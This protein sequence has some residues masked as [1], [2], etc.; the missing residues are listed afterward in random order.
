MF[1]KTHIFF[2]SRLGDG[3]KSKTVSNTKNC[4][5]REQQQRQPS[6]WDPHL[7]ELKEMNNLQNN[8]NN[9][10]ESKC[11][12]EAITCSGCS[13]LKKNKDDINRSRSISMVHQRG[14]TNVQ[15][16]SHC[17]DEQASLFPSGKTI[18]PSKIHRSRSKTVSTPFQI[19]SNDLE[20]VATESNGGMNTRKN[21]QA[22]VCSYQNI[23]RMDFTDRRSNQSHVFCDAD[24]LNDNN[25]SD[26]ASRCKTVSNVSLRLLVRNRTRPTTKYTQ[27][28]HLCTKAGNSNATAVNP[29]MKR[30]K[31]TL[32]STQIEPLKKHIVLRSV[33]PLLIPG[34]KT[35]KSSTSRK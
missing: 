30:G 17:M 14:N 15:C 19:T 6:D 2:D 28:V 32:S 9:N 5:I 3:F 11:P 35:K 4:Q 8:N 26:A 10:S 7:D 27:S 20:T 34:N 31:R 23:P 33:S 29:S 18:N 24:R 13:T 21:S 12:N 22:R 25:I 16:Y 1:D